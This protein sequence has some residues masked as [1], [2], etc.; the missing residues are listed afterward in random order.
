MNLKTTNQVAIEN[1]IQN[2]KGKNLKL[3]GKPDHI[4]VDIPLLSD[5]FGTPHT[6]FYLAEK[7]QN[8]IVE[9]RERGIGRLVS[10]D[11]G[12][13]LERIQPFGFY[14]KG[15][16]N[17]HP[18]V[19]G[20]IDFTGNVIVSNSFPQSVLES[21]PSDNCVVTC[22]TP[23]VPNPVQLSDFSLLGRLDGEI[24][25]LSFSELSECEE[26]KEALVRAITGYTKQIAFSATKINTKSKRGVISSNVLQLAPT[27]NPP[28]KKGTIIYDESDDKIKYY[29]GNKWR[30]FICEDVE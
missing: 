15:D 10:T 18:C 22:S 24:V 27:S 30:S 17:P 14:V 8:D 1:A 26:F 25:S 12:Y 3:L 29:D 2:P 16:S 6:F 4:S 28:T 9:L 19:N 21:L 11:D 20:P 23:F 5:L 7:I 13:E